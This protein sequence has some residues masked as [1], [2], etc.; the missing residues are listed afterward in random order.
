ML[1][2]VHNHEECVRHLWKIQRLDVDAVDFDGKG[3]AHYAITNN[4][5]FLKF[6]MYTMKV[7]FDIKDNSGRPVLVGDAFFNQSRRN[8]ISEDV[9]DWL[10]DEV[11]SP[12]DMYYKDDSGQT[13]ILMDYICRNRNL[14]LDRIKYWIEKRGVDPGFVGQ[15][16]KTVFD[17]QEDESMEE[18]FTPE[19]REY[20]SSLQNSFKGSGGF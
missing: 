20:F 2:L 7:P 17:Y 14:Q 13:S 3:L 19:I 9:L 16:G 10:I 1:F 6:M 4:L 8:E 18:K 5:E 12:K 15:E 11:G